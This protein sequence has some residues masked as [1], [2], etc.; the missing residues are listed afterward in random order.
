MPTHFIGTTF[1]SSYTYGPEEQEVFNILTE[2]IDAKFPNEKNALISLTWFGPQFANFPGWNQVVECYNNQITFDN[3]FLV[4]TVDP[5]YLSVTEIQQLKNLLKALKVF[6][7]G[8]FD[9]P[10]QFNFFA[11]YAAD[12]FKKYSDDELLLTHINKIY[13]NYNRKPREHRVLFVKKLIELNL[14]D[15]GTVTLGK[16]ET[17][18]LFLTLGEKDDDYIEYGNASGQQGFGLPHDLFSLHRLDIWKET[19]LCIVAA[20]EFNPVENLFCQQDTFKPMIGLRPFVFNGNQ[21]TYRWL[22]SNGFRT[23]NHY[24][25][26]IDIEFGNVH[27]T[28]IDLIQYLKSI[29]AT[30][31]MNMYRDMLP[32]LHYNKQRFFEFSKEQKNLIKNIFK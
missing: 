11:A 26:H 5:P 2:Q 19:F 4:A 9:S 18:D 13:V 10:H 12:K 24:W 27:D 15:C 23:F 3:I 25:D 17:N 22:R 8:N 30:E 20:T 32:D 31:R 1:P 28:L 7:L 29:S 16:D 6:Y 14:L 21:K